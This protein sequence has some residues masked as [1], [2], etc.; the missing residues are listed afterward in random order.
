MKYTITLLFLISFAVSGFAQ[1]CSK[2]YPFKK[3]KSVTLEQYNHKNKKQGSITYTVNS[4]TI[5]GGKGKGEV[6]AVYRDARN[7]S[8]TNTFGITCSSSGGV[9]IDYRYLTG[10]SFLS[11]YQNMEVSVSGTD[12]VIPNNL[13]EGS[14]L[15]DAEIQMK[16]SMAAGISMTTVMTVE[17]RKVV[18]KEKVTTPAGTFD[19]VVIDQTLNLKM[20]LGS[21]RMKEKVWI[22]ENTGVVRSESYNEKGS[23]SAYAILTSVTES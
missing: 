15:P 12:L 1:V 13:T 11:Q 2:Y 3:G 18:G 20:N 8:F 21:K 5:T 9:V 17:N 23:M 7:N 10:N 22:A 6:N 4:A 14:R 19:C 16:I